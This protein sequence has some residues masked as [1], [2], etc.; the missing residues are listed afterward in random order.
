MYG[1]PWESGIMADQS[2]KKTECVIYG[3]PWES[4]IMAD[5]SLKK[6]VCNVWYAMGIR[7]YGR[8]KS[9]K[10]QSVV[11]VCHGTKV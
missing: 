10:R 2:L 8:P 7:N 4:G 11:M 6:T 3:M 5:Q 9:E 1:M